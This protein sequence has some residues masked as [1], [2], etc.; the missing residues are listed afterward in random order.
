MQS[1]KL[2]QSQ[3][4]SQFCALIVDMSICGR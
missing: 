3:S 1:S 2:K 4:L